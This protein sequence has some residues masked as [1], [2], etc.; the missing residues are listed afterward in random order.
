MG[1]IA[2]LWEGLR[3]VRG[4]LLCALQ[5]ADAPGRRALGNLEE[6]AAETA[7]LPEGVVSAERLAVAWGQL[8][9]L[10]VECGT[11]GAPGARELPWRRVRRTAAE[12]LQVLLARPEWSSLARDFQEEVLP[13]FTD[14]VAR[15]YA[16]RVNRCREAVAHLRWLMLRTSGMPHTW[17]LRRVAEMQYPYCTADGWH[18]R[19][20]IDFT[21]TRARAV[22]LAILEALPGGETD[23]RP[24]VVSYDGRIHAQELA[25][26]AVELAS[27][28]G[29]PVH[30]TRRAT[31]TPA[32]RQYCV[33]ALGTSGTSGMI[34][35]TA[36]RLPIKDQGNQHYAGHE[37]QG[38]C[39]T[40]PAGDPPEMELCRRISRRAAELLVDPPPA[41][42]AV[43][44][45][46]VTLFDPRQAYLTRL[47][48][49]MGG[50]G[51]AEPKAPTRAGEEAPAA[52]VL[53]AYW[54]Q[55]GA[56]IVID[57][58]HGAARGYLSALCAQLMLPYEVLHGEED[59]LF[60]ELS[61]ACPQ[62]PHLAELSER[63]KELRAPGQPR[64]GLALDADGD[65]LGVV[66]EHGR[67][68]AGNAVLLL[69]AD[70]CLHE[71]YPGIAGVVWRSR[72]ATRALERLLS[73]AE[74]A[75]RYV[76]P[77]TPE[78]LPG[79]MRRPEYISLYG[80]P[81]LLHGV[82]VLVTEDMLGTSEEW[83]RVGG[84]DSMG[85]SALLI[86]GDGDGAL[87]CSGR[88]GRDGMRAALLL[89]QL[90]AARES[91]IS[92]LWEQL[93]QK[94]GKTHTDYLTLYAPQMI[95]RT[96]IDRLLARYLRA[97]AAP[98]PPGAFRFGG[99]TVEFAGG[100]A[101][102]FIE[103]ALRDAEGAPAYAG[104][105]HWPL[106]G[107]VRVDAEAR[108]AETVH[109]LLIHIA[110]RLDALFKERL[111]RAGNPWQVMELLATVTSPLALHAELPGTLTCRLAEEAYTRLQELA[112]PGREAPELMRFITERL[113][114]LRPD[115]ARALAAC[116]LGE[117]ADAPIP[118]PIPHVRW[119][120]ED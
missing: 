95:G 11:D 4:E 81:H 29:R 31:P 1:E 3:G 92:D 17:R 48:G 47:L 9:L 109:R 78:G 87:A 51:S 90:C 42:R 120:G 76:S 24:L 62:P 102:R 43:P 36:S 54:R 94:I 83:H 106:E 53:R 85:E 56:R 5:R 93:Q 105:T 13:L 46:N 23:L 18:E 111:H 28:Q 69:L 89:L 44:S 86:G 77:P 59:V 10:L 73:G 117:P 79:Y 108:D 32:L 40:L 65:R 119:E 39:L 12:G 118:P 98:A 96:F 63:L 33:E 91:P 107:A 101:E 49:E 116:H 45:G 80:D 2:E 64:I 103:F 55:P 21:W 30:F 41:P 114:E 70:Y 57:E 113:R 110:E 61:A 104:I 112:R 66:D 72:G 60:G 6:W 8:Q 16:G 100:M 74:V 38:I 27:R 37:Y 25:T 7:A 14:A 99:C 82:G 115:N 88:G 26:L 67:Y 52:D 19:M 84:E 35:C 15:D 97:G 58:M 22:L 75:G 50:R 71:G 20:G 34:N 68:L